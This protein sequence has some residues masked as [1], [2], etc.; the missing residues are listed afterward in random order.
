MLPSQRVR[1]EWRG[2]SVRDLSA[3]GSPR[4]DDSDAAPQTNLLHHSFVNIL[5]NA[6]YTPTGNRLCGRPIAK[7]EPLRAVYDDTLQA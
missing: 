4:H 6:Y 1:C 3:R 2:H 7:P 5:L